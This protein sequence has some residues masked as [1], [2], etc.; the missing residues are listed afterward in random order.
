MLFNPKEEHMKKY[1][2]QYKYTNDGLA[3]EFISEFVTTDDLEK[4]WNDEI[5]TKETQDELLQ[6]VKL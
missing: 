2:V 6:V 3:Y 1:W 5:W 4:Y